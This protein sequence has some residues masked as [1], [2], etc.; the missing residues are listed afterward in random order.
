MG[1]C[2]GCL[3]LSGRKQCISLQA[4]LA[5]AKQR[6]NRKLL[7]TVAWPWHKKA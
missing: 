2:E 6:S 3:G 4:N 5:A 7:P 1:P